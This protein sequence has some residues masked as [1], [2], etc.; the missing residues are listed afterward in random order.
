MRVRQRMLNELAKPTE[1]RVWRTHPIP[2]I[3][4]D[5]Q[6][7]SSDPLMCRIPTAM[8]EQCIRWM[9]DDAQAVNDRMLQILRND[10][11]P[12]KNRDA[13][14]AAIR[15]MPSVE[16]YVEIYRAMMEG[17][18]ARKEFVE[19]AILS[20][21]MLMEYHAMEYLRNNEKNR[22][23]YGADVDNSHKEGF[24]GRSTW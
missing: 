23:K 8:L 24:V 2:P 10:D 17:V 4:Q 7:S 3:L 22:R 13:C 1:Q 15:V 20:G 6:V 18:A 21:H 11:Y 16:E 9:R 14:R 19:D 5:T 12:Q